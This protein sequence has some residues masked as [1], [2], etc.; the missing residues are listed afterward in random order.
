MAAVVVL[1]VAG[2]V[3]VS[4]VAV[5]DFVCSTMPDI[6]EPIPEYDWVGCLLQS[7]RI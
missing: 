5:A 7:Q 4:A 6:A 1:E 3:A 2:A